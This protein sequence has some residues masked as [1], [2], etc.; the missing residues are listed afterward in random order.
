MFQ[1]ADAAESRDSDSDTIP[2]EEIPN[3]EDDE[4]DDDDDDDDDGKLT[5]LN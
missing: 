5:L 3:V 4:D 1:D 2:S